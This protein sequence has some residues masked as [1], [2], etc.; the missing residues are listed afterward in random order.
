MSLQKFLSLKNERDRFRSSRAH[1]YD[2]SRSFFGFEKNSRVLPCFLKKMLG[3]QL[4][5]AFFSSVEKA[6]T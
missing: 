4:L 2:S 5:Y 6:C 3:F 1:L